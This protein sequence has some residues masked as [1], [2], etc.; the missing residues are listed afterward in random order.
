MT[1]TQLT[2]LKAAILAETNTTFVSYRNAGATGAMADWYNGNSN[3]DAW[4]TSVSAIDLDEAADYTS[5]DSIAAGKRDSWRFFLQYAP[6]DMSKAKNRKVVTDV[7]GNAVAN[8][9]SE[10]ILK[11]CTEKA[12]KGELVYPTN[13]ATTGTV[14]AV[15]RDFVG[16]ILNQDIID[17]LGS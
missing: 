11:S 3:T 13:S 2:T 8:S 15:K 17:A 12:L 16:R 14:T 7:W 1:P 6:R 9:I 4:K 10:G 5:F